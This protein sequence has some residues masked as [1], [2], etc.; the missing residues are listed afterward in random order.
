MSSEWWLPSSKIV[1]KGRGKGIAG[2]IQIRVQD[3]AF[4]DT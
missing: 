3:F 1:I 2:Q 4:T